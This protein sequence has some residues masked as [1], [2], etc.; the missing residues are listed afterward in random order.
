MKSL[1]SNH[2]R[3]YLRH[4]LV[5]NKQ[6]KKAKQG[7]RAKRGRCLIILAKNGIVLKKT[8]ILYRKAKRRILRILRI[9]PK[10]TRMTTMTP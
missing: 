5:A 1:I 6:I 3:Y 10:N 7:T 2:K 4:S 8:T 9:R